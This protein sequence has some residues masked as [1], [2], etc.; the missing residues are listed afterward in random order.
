M[1]VWKRIVRGLLI[2]LVSLALLYE[3]VGNVIIST[4]AL[5]GLTNVTPDVLTVDYGRAWTLWP[6]T[7][8]V[9]DLTVRFQD[10]NIQFLLRLDEA[11]V[12]IALWSLARKEFHATRVR[13]TGASWR[14][15]LKTDDAKADAARLE[16]YPPI[17][18]ARPAVRT[19]VVGPPA[20]PAKLWTVRLDDVEAAVRE[21]W[22]VEFAWHGAGHVQGAFELQP[23]R[24]LWVG[25]ALL[26]L[27]PGT[28]S[29]GPTQASRDF[30]LRADVDVAPYDIQTHPAMQVF[31]PISASIQL[32]GHLDDLSFANRY[33]PHLAVAGRGSVDAD[34]RLIAGKLGP[35]TTVALKLDSLQVRSAE[36]IA[37][38]VATMRAALAPGTSRPTVTGEAGGVV[39]AEL[40]GQPLMV[41]LN[42][43]NL[44]LVLTNHD[45]VEG[46]VL[47]SASAH[48]TAGRLEDARALKVA[49]AKR[50]PIVLPELLGDGPLIFS[51]TAYLT[52][53][54]TLV[55]LTDAR[56]GAARLRGV[57]L[58]DGG[59][60]R[61]AG[62]G[63]VG[64]VELG[65]RLEAGAL[66][67][68]PFVGPQWLGE[69]FERMKID[70]NLAEPSPLAAF[71]M[72]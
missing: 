63:H 5:R 33:P 16:A 35:A 14:M 55:Q 69:E 13:A 18:Y 45:L 29:I 40:E 6:G 57:A 61:A 11:E 8:H 53:A 54:Q 59:V 22:V 26:T 36:F 17:G 46:V 2:G 71:N 72:R 66:Q 20:D 49:A 28:L 32:A 52:P 25:P 4:D 41:Q 37:D 65:A 3:V 1:P 64:G 67:V 48:V 70:P 43:V 44:D 12:D 15:L 21:V 47:E 50:V 10:H 51:G 34:L 31:R 30:S 27:E 24:R 38:G 56:L 68:L 7:V 23:R 19:P 58:T 42:Q 62:E 60:W 39:R 9:K